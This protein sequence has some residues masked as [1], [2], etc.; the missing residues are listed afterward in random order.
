MAAIGIVREWHSDEGWGV[1][2]SDTTPGGCW[3][4]FGS[5]Y[6]VAEGPF[7]PRQERR[8]H[9]DRPA[10]RLG[11]RIGNP[12]WD[13]VGD[14]HDQVMREGDRL[15]HPVGDLLEHTGLP[16]HRYGLPILRLDRVG[17]VDD[18][19]LALRVSLIAV[20]VTRDD[21]EAGDEQRPRE[22]SPQHG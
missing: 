5:V 22:S 4:H 16:D 3:A 17:L 21:C 15:A 11:D 13:L 14:L 10:V 18:R 7:D 8:W 19:D 12:W 9:K 20:A 1:I 2:D 6:H